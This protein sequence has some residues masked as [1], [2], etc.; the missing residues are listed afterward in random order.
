MA[1]RAAL[2]RAAEIALTDLGPTTPA[3]D[4]LRDAWKAA[5]GGLHGGRRARIQASAQSWLSVVTSMISFQR[6]AR[7]GRRADDGIYNWATGFG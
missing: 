3:V 6:G 1:Y 2:W 4:D 5:Y 7:R